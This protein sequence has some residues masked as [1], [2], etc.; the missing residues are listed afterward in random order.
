MATNEDSSM[1][2]LKD[3][4]AEEAKK[5]AEAHARRL[6]LLAEYEMQHMAAQ[7]NV[8]REA[9]EILQN[10]LGDYLPK[11]AALHKKA[12]DYLFRRELEKALP[13]ARKRRKAAKP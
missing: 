7:E 9:V 4:R 1:V 6:R 10:H 3:Q 12:G 13:A 11:F 2:G 8:A 5:H